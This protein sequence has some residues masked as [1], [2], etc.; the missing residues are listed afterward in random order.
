LSQVVR[1][2]TWEEAC[3]HTPGSVVAG[4]TEGNGTDV[5]P[6][7]VHRGVWIGDDKVAALGVRITRGLSM[8]GFALNVCVKLEDYAGIVPCGIRDRGVVSMDRLV[9]GVRLASVKPAVVSAFQQEFGYAHVVS[10]T[11][12][13]WYAAMFD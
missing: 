11:Y 10:P 2:Q 7:A 5:L 1:G 3:Q 4:L 12:A 9:P 8:H 13:A 6:D